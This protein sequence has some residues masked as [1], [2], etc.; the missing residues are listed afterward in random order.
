MLRG[1]NLC[2]TYPKA[3]RFLDGVAVDARIHPREYTLFEI[4]EAVN[5]KP[6]WQLLSATT[7]VPSVT[8][9]NFK[10]KLNKFML[11]ALLRFPMGEF[12]SVVAEKR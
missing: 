11:K 4:A 1:R 12:I 2:E 5:D 7:F 10:T 9:S 8:P 3:P 6:E